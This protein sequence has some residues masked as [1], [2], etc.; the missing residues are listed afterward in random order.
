M[1]QV[2][3]SSSENIDP[4]TRG[5][6]LR[7]KN[8]NGTTIDAVTLRT[9]YLG[10]VKRR[11][12]ANIT[13]ANGVLGLNKRSFTMP[14][15]NG[16]TSDKRLAPVD[17][18][19]QL[20]QHVKCNVKTEY[21]EG[22]SKCVLTAS[23]VSLKSSRKSFKNHDMLSI[24]PVFQCGECG[25]IV[26][27]LHSH[28][29][30]WCHRNISTAVFQAPSLCEH[31]T[32][33]LPIVSFGNAIAPPVEHFHK[34]KQISSDVKQQCNTSHITMRHPL[35]PPTNIGSAHS[36]VKLSVVRNVSGTNCCFPWAFDE[37]NRNDSSRKVTVCPVCGCSMRVQ[38]ASQHML[39]M[40]GR[41]V[42][43]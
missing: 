11:P 42:S 10:K 3:T 6:A 30:L 35:M 5:N 24:A 20:K 7:T 15:R 40:H 18:T 43:I 22:K 39:I 9:N 21:R 14:M 37:P 1:P 17:S 33:P 32:E 28:R 25:D 8:I 26:D 31:Q 38:H 41:N 12:F 4:T 19:N 2:K 23:S 34:D 36:S 27:D 13:L 29:R 16:S